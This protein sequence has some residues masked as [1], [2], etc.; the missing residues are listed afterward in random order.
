M[1][2]VAVN[3]LLLSGVMIYGKLQ[4]A[5]EGWLLGTFFFFFSVNNLF[6]SFYVFR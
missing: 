4:T 6:P 2:S 1:H 3:V 5:V